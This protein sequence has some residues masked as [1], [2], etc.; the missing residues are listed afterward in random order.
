MSLVR[1]FTVLIFDFKV[2]KKTWKNTKIPDFTAK[3]IYL[4]LWGDLKLS[5]LGNCQLQSVKIL[6]LGEKNWKKN[7]RFL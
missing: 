1:E 6:T 7:T 5:I 2:N 3:K 4:S